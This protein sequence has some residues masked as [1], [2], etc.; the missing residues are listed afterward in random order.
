MSKLMSRDLKYLL[1][2]VL[3]LVGDDIVGRLDELGKE[4]ES[5]GGLKNACALAWNL[6][7]VDVESYSFKECV[8]WIKA[9]INKE[10]ARGAFVHK[11]EGKSSFH[12]KYELNVFFFDADKNPLKGDNNSWLIVHCNTLDNDFIQNFGN[13]D[14]LVL[15]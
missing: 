8:S 3:E 9:H 5:C 4:I 12:K 2:K 10:N 1:D 13:K 7:E 11:K 14:T 15:Q 6:E